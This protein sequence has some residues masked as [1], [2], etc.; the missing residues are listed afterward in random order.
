MF[1]IEIGRIADNNIYF[2]VVQFYL[3]INFV[4]LLFYSNTIEKNVLCFNMCFFQF[5]H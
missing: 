1:R 5:N 2:A 4:P 3:P